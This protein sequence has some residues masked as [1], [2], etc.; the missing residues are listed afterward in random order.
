MEDSLRTPP[1]RPDRP[2]P[3]PYRR[4]RDAAGGDALGLRPADPRRQGAA[5]GASNYSAARL[6]EA[7]AVAARENLPRYECLQ[8]GYSLADREEYEAEL[9]PL[10]REEGIGVISYF[11]SG[12]GLPHR[13]VPRGRALPPAAP[14]RPGSRATSTRRASPSSTSSTRSPGT[15]ARDAGP[16]RHRLARRAAGADRADRQR[17]LGGAAR[18]AARRRAPRPR[19]GGI[20]P[21]G[22][23][24]PGHAQGLT[25]R[26]GGSLTGCGE[27]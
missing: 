4:C 24:Q 7:F 18:R 13:Q 1:D 2:L 27:T 19:P 9:E 6:R 10:C 17:H 22:G 8:P 16:G 11:S 25:P 3:V 12:R 15:T 21:A 14:G 20:R 5:I 23:S 26:V